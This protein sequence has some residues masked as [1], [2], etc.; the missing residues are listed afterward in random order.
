MTSGF[1]LY[2]SQL[3]TCLQEMLTIGVKHPS[4][5][6]HKLA[7]APLCISVGMLEEYESLGEIRLL[8]EVQPRDR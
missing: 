6:F 1:L 4:G 3:T 7:F 2:L 8:R 5:Q